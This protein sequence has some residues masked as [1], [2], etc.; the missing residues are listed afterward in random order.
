MVGNLL[1]YGIVIHILIKRTLSFCL[2]VFFT[3]ITEV[4]I[5]CLFWFFSS[6]FSRVSVDYIMVNENRF[7]PNGFILSVFLVPPKSTKFNS[8]VSEANW[9]RPEVFYRE[10]LVKNNVEPGL[11]EVWEVAY[12]HNENLRKKFHRA[13]SA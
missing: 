5:I 2:F 11:A 1:S 12:L 7:W 6:N 10:I 9:T 13:S 4:N 3:L 8:E